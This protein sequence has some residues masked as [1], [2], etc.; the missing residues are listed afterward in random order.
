[1]HYV[2]QGNGDPVLFLHGI[3][4]SAYSFRNIMPPVSGSARTIALDFMGFGQSAKP[5]IDYSFN[6][7]LYYLEK[8]IEK[9]DFR[10]DHTGDDRYRWD[11]RI[12]ICHGAP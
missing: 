3:P 12:K 5:E 10:A 1:M 8:F 6:D 4:M 2:E 11:N 7:Q 9:L